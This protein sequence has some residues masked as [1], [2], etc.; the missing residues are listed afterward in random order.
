LEIIK[1]NGHPTHRLVLSSQ[2]EG[3]PLATAKTKAH[4]VVP[5]IDQIDDEM[6]KQQALP[7]LTEKENEKGDSYLRWTRANLSVDARSSLSNH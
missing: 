7:V 2:Q 6:A 5:A 3:T 4:L 1:R